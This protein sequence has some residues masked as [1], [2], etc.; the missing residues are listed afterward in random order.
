M[1]PKFN[2][3]QKVTVTPVKNPTVSPRDSD[4][5][6]YAGSNGKVIDYYWLS[7]SM[8]EA[9]YVYTVRIEAENKDIVLHE[10]EIQACL[11]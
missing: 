1:A 3:G 2:K 9:F 5:R 6:V 8:G 10:D 4:I 11:V 7:T